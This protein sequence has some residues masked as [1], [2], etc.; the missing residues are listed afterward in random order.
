MQI[1]GPHHDGDNQHTDSQYDG[2]CSLIFHFLQQECYAYWID[3]CP[4]SRHDIYV[5]RGKAEDIMDDCIE[6]N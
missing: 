4:M 6:Q 2:Y 5:A 1:I 3:E